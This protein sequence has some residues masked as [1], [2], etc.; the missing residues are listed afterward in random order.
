M[1]LMHRSL[2][3]NARAIKSILNV[4]PFTSVR[5]VLRTSIARGRR[6]ALATCIKLRPRRRHRLRYLITAVGLSDVMS[7]TSQAAIRDF[8][9]LQRVTYCTF[10]A[11]PEDVMRGERQL[12][13]HSYRLFI[14]NIRHSETARQGCS[15]EGSLIILI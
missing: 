8:N 4:L 10:I 9:R 1:S 5:G 2:I 11:F 15:F 13:T 3:T 12:P 14:P 6:I 7:I